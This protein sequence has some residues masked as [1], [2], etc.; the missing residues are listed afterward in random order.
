M[1]ATHRTLL[2]LSLSLHLDQEYKYLMHAH[3]LRNRDYTSSQKR[4]F[5]F[6][7]I[8]DTCLALTSCTWNAMDLFPGKF[9]RTDFHQ[10]SF[11]GSRKWWPWG[12]WNL[13]GFHRP[14]GGPLGGGDSKLITVFLQVY[15]PDSAVILHTLA[16]VF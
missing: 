5:K 6:L 3:I 4:M 12:R 11:G 1:R 16:F 10:R 15:P 9:G 2:E 8:G 14:P 13:T 7:V